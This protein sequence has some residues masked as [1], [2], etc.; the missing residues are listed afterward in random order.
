MQ[1]EENLITMYDYI[2]M[3]LSIYKCKG[4]RREETTVGAYLDGGSL[5]NININRSQWT[6][7]L[8]KIISLTKEHK[9]AKIIVALDAYQQYIKSTHDSNYKGNRPSKQ[10]V[11]TKEEYTILFQRLMEECKIPY[12]YGPGLEADDLIYSF[13]K[14]TSKDKQILILTNDSDV[15]VNVADNVDVIRDIRANL[16][17]II[18]KENFKYTE[19]NKKKYMFNT[20]MINK[21]TEGDTSDNIDPLPADISKKFYDMLN[22]IR[23][24]TSFGHESWSDGDFID[25][26]VDLME[27]DDL[28]DSDEL[29]ILRHNV[30]MVKPILVNYEEFSYIP[31]QSID[32]N[33]LKSYYNLIA[34]RTFPAIKAKQ[35]DNKVFRM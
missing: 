31:T 4:A 33:E 9:G 28:L 13:V 2:L 23:V 14:Q 7:P 30:F 17:T 29:K 32:M 11:N 20:I 15:L 12:L 26:V 25:G 22:N 5:H 8:Q 1:L 16:K 18:T 21:I 27:K 3:D 10:E 6:I 35:L 34:P 19:I 24:R